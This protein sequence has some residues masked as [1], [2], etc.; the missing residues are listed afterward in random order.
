MKNTLLRQ[1]QNDISSEKLVATLIK[2]I[3]F[4]LSGGVI[5]NLALNFLVLPIFNNNPLLNVFFTLISNVFV[6]IIISLLLR[7]NLEYL[8]LLQTEAKLLGLE[9]PEVCIPLE[10][11]NELTDIAKDLNRLQE[12][13][14]TK[15]KA[16]SFAKMENHRIITSVSNEVHAPLTSII[17]YLER[18][19]NQTENDAE[20]SAAYLKT[21]LKKTYLV[22]KFIDN[23]FEHA[24]T[25]NGKGYYQFK[26]YNGKPLINQLL[27]STTQALE[28]GGFKVILEDCIE[29]DFSLWIDLEQ[30]QRIFDYLV[31]NIIK[32]ADPDKSIDLGLILNKNELCMILRNKTNYTSEGVGKTVLATED[33]SLDTCRKIIT[34]HQGR[35]DYYQLNQLFKVELILPIHHK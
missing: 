9:D 2:M 35:I 27:K 29:Q 31:S 3:F 33:S 5:L 20:K 10:N 16:E 14:Q 28:E 23:L 11:N 25:D 8:K 1:D 17:G 26:V 22:K 13:Y 15:V 30:L 32:Y 7:K 6:F 21:A 12:L 18:I 24:F 19:Q 34:R 4:T